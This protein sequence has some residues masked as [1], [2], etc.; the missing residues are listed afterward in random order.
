MRQKGRLADSPASSLQLLD[1][2][3][4]ALRAHGAVEDDL[5]LAVVIEADK[6]RLPTLGASS[7]FVAARLAS[8][9]PDDERV[10]G[11]A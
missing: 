3:E 10:G 5:V 11:R 8:L 6:Q 9:A 7:C 4:L 1:G 2:V